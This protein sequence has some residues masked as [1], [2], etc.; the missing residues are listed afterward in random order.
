MVREPYGDDAN[1][2]PFSEDTRECLVCGTYLYSFE[3]DEGFCGYCLEGDFDC[4]L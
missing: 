4:E 1:C 3:W 2:W